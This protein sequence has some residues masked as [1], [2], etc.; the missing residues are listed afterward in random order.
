MVAQVCCCD[1][2]VDTRLPNCVAHCVVRVIGCRMS[3]ACRAQDGD[4][5]KK[6]VGLCTPKLNIAF[7]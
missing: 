5:G 4:H 7:K 1:Y 6:A 2:H 3:E